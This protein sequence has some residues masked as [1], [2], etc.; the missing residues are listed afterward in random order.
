MQ[1]DYFGFL[2]S[3]PLKGLVQREVTGIAHGR[4]DIHFVNGGTKTVA[5]LKKCHDDFTLPQMVEKYGLQATAYQRTN[6]RFCILLVLDLFDR[7]GGGDHLLNLIDVIAKKPSFAQ[8]EY[9][10]VTIRVQGR[11]QSPSSLSGL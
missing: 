1:R 5:E 4:A 9:S 3:T 11:K 8:A 7:K 6:V 10:I 2:Q